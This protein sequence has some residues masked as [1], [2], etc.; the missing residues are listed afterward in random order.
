MR[1]G[2]PRLCL[3]MIGLCPGAMLLTAQG[4][5]VLSPSTVD[6]GDV[7][8]GQSVTQLVTLTNNTPYDQYVVAQL[9]GA[10]LVDFRESNNCSYKTELQDELL[11]WAGTSCTITVVFIPVIPGFVAPQVNIVAYSGST[12]TL[13]VPLS[14]TGIGGNTLAASPSTF[15]AGA[16]GLFVTIDESGNVSY[17]NPG[18]YDNPGPTFRFTIGNP[19]TSPLAAPTLD[20]S[21][22][23][24]FLASDDCPTV[25]DV[26][27]TCTVYVVFMPQGIGPRKGSIYV[28]VPPNGVNIQLTGTG[29]VNSFDNSVLGNVLITNVLSGKTLDVTNASTADGARIQQ[30]AINGGMQQNWHFLPNGNNYVIVSA[31]SGDALDVTNASSADGTPIQQWAQNGGEQQLWSIEPAG[32]FSNIVNVLSS[33]ALDVTNASTANGAPI[34]QWSLNGD[35]QQLWQLLPPDGFTIESNVSGKCLDSTGASFANGTPIQQWDCNGSRQQAWF[36]IPVGGGYFK[37]QNQLTGK[38][39]DVTNASLSDGTIIQQWEYNGGWQQ[40]WTIEPTG[41]DVYLVPVE[42]YPEFQIVNRLSGKVLDVSN[43]SVENGALIQ[44]WSSNGFVQQH[45]SLQ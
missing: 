7:E 39:L 4:S 1:A 16:Q 27:A 11:L 23:G 41:V 3:L 10:G 2:W 25:L 32:Q 31:L 40:Q 33:K 13:T 8:T 45:W 26:N 38:V 35:P 5:L 14:G 20:P 19:T 12:T 18:V 37:I 15:N 36:L 22:A 6:F 29:Q 24:D 17:Y 44:Q 21:T 28:G 34:Q 42:T 43:A 9:A 30:W